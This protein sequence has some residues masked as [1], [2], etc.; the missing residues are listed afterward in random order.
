MKW[1]DRQVSTI[2]CVYIDSSW[3]GTETILE[4]GLGG[5]FTVGPV[6]IL[7]VRHEK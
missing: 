4:R 5:Q 2:I 1:E 6:Y 3:E 7:R